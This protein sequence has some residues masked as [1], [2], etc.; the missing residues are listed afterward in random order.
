M[1]R[2]LP[3][4]SAVFQLLFDFL[5]NVFGELP[6]SRYEAN[7]GAD[8]VFGLRQQI[9]RDHCCIAGFVSDD[10]DLARASELVNTYL[11]VNKGVAGASMAFEVSSVP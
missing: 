3:E 9:G 6:V 1:Q 11:T 10:E 7:T 2:L 4:L 5:E 8:V